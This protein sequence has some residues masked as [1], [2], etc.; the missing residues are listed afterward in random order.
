MK[1][2]KKLLK[3]QLVGIIGGAS[4]FV[5]AL[6]LERLQFNTVALVLYIFA[7]VFAGTG[8]AFDAIRGILR[9]DL[10]DEKF[11]MTVA[12]VGAMIIGEHSE[13]VAVMIFFLI[14]EFFEH[15]AVEKVADADTPRRSNGHP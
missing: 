14:G 2:L 1:R 15:K 9:R 12:A 4:F 3:N 13:G 6:V 11:L 7:L 5:P 10:L 8:V